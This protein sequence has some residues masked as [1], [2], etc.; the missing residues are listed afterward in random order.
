MVT[1]RKIVLHECPPIQGG[2]TQVQGTDNRTSPDTAEQRY[3]LA[4]RCLRRRAST[5][6]GG[7]G[8]TGE[9]DS[10]EAFLAGLGS[11]GSKGQFSREALP[12]AGPP[13]SV[14]RFTADPQPLKRLDGQSLPC[15]HEVS[16]VQADH[17]SCSIMAVLPGNWQLLHL[18]TP[19]ALMKS[20]ERL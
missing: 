18:V 1:H 5:H 7:L 9:R 8:E 13:L 17:G 20:R 2:P 10:C 4:V 14:Q 16:D 11:L 15:E 19:R 12:G 6:S 3:V